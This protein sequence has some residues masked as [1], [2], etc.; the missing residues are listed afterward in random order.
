MMFGENRASIPIHN[1]LIPATWQSKFDTRAIDSRL[2]NADRQASLSPSNHHS[3]MP[4]S[5]SG[6]KFGYHGGGKPKSIMN[7]GSER[8]ITSEKNSFAP[9]TFF[10]ESNLS[11]A[12][13]RPAALTPL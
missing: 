6:L 12:P 9:S 7:P 4:A 5:L 1:W 8:A 2:I 3:A 11:H 10:T 13:R